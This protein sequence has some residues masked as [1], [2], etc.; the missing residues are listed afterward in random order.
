MTTVDRILRK[1]DDLAKEQE[2][3]LTLPALNDVISQFEAALAIPYSEAGIPLLITYLD[4]ADKPK[5][6]ILTKTHHFS[7]EPLIHP[8]KKKWNSS[9]LLCVCTCVL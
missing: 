4:K 5:K 7:F 2:E 9:I 1:L 3:H 8:K 6:T